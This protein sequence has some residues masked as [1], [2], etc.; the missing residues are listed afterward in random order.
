ML[1]ETL[2]K[3]LATSLTL[4]A[5]IISLYVVVRFI[6]R[7]SQPIAIEITNHI[8]L[9]VFLLWFAAYAISTNMELDAMRR[10]FDPEVLPGLSVSYGLLAF[11]FSISFALLIITHRNLFLSFPIVMI[12]GYSDLYGNLNLMTGM[13]YIVSEH[14]KAGTIPSEPARIW[15]AY[16]LANEHLIRIAM[17]MLISYAGFMIFLAG[18]IG[19]TVPQAVSA[20]K[21]DT[22]AKAKEFLRKHSIPL[23]VMGKIVFISALLINEVTIWTW[24]Y[25]REQKFMATGNQAQSGYLEWSVSG[26]YKFKPEPSESDGEQ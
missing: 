13:Q 1:P 25:E 8:V 2:D 21:K 11:A 10:V 6:R 24:R 12:L 16:Y 22:A 19:T 3:L 17:Y 20:A 23:E 7:N 26:F 15:I 18:R 5:A 9:V 4:I 14:Q